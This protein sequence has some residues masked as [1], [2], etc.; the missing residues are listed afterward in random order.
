MLA[1]RIAY[2]RSAGGDD[3]NDHRRR[4]GARGPG[5]GPRPGRRRAPGRGPDPLAT[6]TAP[7]NGRDPLRRLERP[8]RRRLGPPGGR[9]RRHREPG[10][11]NHRRPES[12]RDLRTTLDPREE[13]PHSGES[14][15]RRTSHCR[16]GR[17]GESQT[18]NPDSDV[19]RRP[20]RPEGK[21]AAGRVRPARRR[22]PGQRHPGLG[23][24]HAR[25][26]TPGCAASHH[27]DRA[28]AQ[29]SRRAVP[30]GPAP[31]PALRRRAPG[32]R[33]P[34]LLLDPRRRPATP[35]CAS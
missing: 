13:T 3:A 33:P 6:A 1:R 30:R 19:C 35:R 24:L 12:R 5:L 32:Q 2:D 9:S 25:G 23:R 21:R 8:H 11:R 15:P 10:R 29:H 31:I 14:P 34:G 17:R 22:L 27:A 4:N 16:R 26:R 28:G 18:E 7:G 20:L